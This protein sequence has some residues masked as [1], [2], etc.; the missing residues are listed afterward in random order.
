MS[1]FDIVHREGRRVC[2]LKDFF[3]SI[4]DGLLHLG[5]FVTLFGAK[6]KGF[7]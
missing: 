3:A 7:V 2:E 6:L 4:R 1:G 5:E